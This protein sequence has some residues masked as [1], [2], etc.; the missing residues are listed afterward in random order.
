MCTCWHMSWVVSGSQRL[1]VRGRRRQVW[2]TVQRW[3]KTTDAQ[4]A[5]E[6]TSCAWQQPNLGWSTGWKINTV[7]AESVLPCSLWVTAV[8][9][10]EWE[11]EDRRESKGQGNVLNQA[12]AGERTNHHTKKGHAKFTINEFPELQSPLFS[13]KAPKSCD[14]FDPKAGQYCGTLYFITKCLRCTSDDC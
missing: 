10:G 4:K 14:D 1:H 8:K 12:E 6:L 13:G 5:E 2:C 11:S 9:W 7:T 3:Q